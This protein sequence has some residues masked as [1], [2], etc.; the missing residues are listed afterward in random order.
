[1]D[2]DVIPTPRAAS[3]VLVDVERLEVLAP[4][5]L[6]AVDNEVT[7]VLESDPSPEPALLRLVEIEEISPATDV[8]KDVS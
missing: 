2:K 5:V 8:D 1:V 7:A 3:A 4:T 6:T